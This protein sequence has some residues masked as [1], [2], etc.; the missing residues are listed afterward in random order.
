MF[1]L[2]LCGGLVSCRVK[3]NVFG[4][5]FQVTYVISNEL[6]DPHKNAYDFSFSGKVR[7]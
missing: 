4:I 2:W 1:S 5:N 3:T 6:F 7:P